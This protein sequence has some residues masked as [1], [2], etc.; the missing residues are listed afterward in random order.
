LLKVRGTT[1]TY[2]IEVSRNYPKEPSAK[3]S[4]PRQSIDATDARID[5]LVYE[6][7]DLTADEIRIVAAAT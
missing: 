5:K 1:I 7:Y 4:G 3:R 2:P 6:L